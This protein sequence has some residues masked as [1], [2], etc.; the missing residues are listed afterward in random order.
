MVLIMVLGINTIK[1]TT[2]SVV[3]EN[4]PI[5]SLRTKVFSLIDI[6]YFFISLFI[7]FYRVLATSY[8]TMNYFLEYLKIL[9]SF[10]WKN[11]L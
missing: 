11:L 9:I 8:R 2:Y 3:M 5:R 1:K 7:A 4:R 10:L 6:L